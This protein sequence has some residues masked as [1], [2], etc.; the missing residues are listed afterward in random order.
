MRIAVAGS[1][2][3]IGRQVVARATAQGHEIVE[4]ARSL[5]FDL[6]H[7]DA[8]LVEALTGADAVIDVTQSPTLDEAEAT[9]FFT[10][11][12]ENLGTAATKAGVGRTVLLS[13]VGV[14]RSADYGYYV[15]KLAQERAT[16]ESAP[17]PVV[18]RATQFH[19]F[20]EQMLA[21]NTDGS[22]TRIID[23]PT[24]PVDTAEIVALLLAAATGEVGGDVD[25]AG[26]KV[27]R[28][29]D[30]VRHLVERRGLALTVEAVP[31]PPSLAGGSM[32]PGP[33]ALLRGPDWATWLD[34]RLSA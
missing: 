1:T 30:Q 28:L 18:V 5:G 17:S 32:L 14:D 34:G 9:A 6:R 7:P 2:G 19:D 21:W 24:Q 25:L 31:A 16:R 15:A 26:P 33:D 29:V 8:N 3:L 20:A 4:I 10:A 13:I 27:E 12:A 22:V 23:V 11:V